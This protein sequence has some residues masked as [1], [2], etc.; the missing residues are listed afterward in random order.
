MAHKAPTRPTETTNA[1]IA[2]LQALNEAA[3]TAPIPESNILQR[4]AL[5]LCNPAA[6]NLRSDTVT[7][8]VRQLKFIFPQLQGSADDT[9]LHETVTAM[10]GH[11]CECEARG[12]N[13]ERLLRQGTIMRPMAAV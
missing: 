5:S 13:A 8:L 10:M 4:L 1:A 2:T 6:R 9:Q 3:G 11:L 12:L 7:S